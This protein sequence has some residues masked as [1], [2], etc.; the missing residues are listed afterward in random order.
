MTRT[1]VRIYAKAKVGM[2]SD[3]DFLELDPEQ[4]TLYQ[5][6]FE[7]DGVNN[8]GIT[9]WRPD[10]LA[11]MV[12]PTATGEDVRRIAQV[13][14]DHKYVM[15]D[16]DTAE[17]LVRSYIRHDDVIRQPNM[18]KPMAA[19]FNAT[20]SRVLRQM[21]A[22]ELHRLCAE[23]RGLA[24]PP[25]GLQT[26]EVI[27][28]LRKYPATVSPERLAAWAAHHP[29]RAR[30]RTPADDFEPE[31][32][33]P[34][35]TPADDFTPAD[36]GEGLG[37]RV[38]GKGSPNPSEDPLPQ[39]GEGLGGTPGERDGVTTT[40]TNYKNKRS[41]VA[42]SAQ[43]ETDPD[44]PPELGLFHA[45]PG[46]KD[47]D[48]DEATADA[49][50]TSADRDPVAAEYEQV[51]KPWAGMNP[52]DRS[53]G[54][55]PKGLT[56]YRAWRKKFPD[57]P[58]AKLVDGIVPVWNSATSDQYV[59]HIDRFIREQLW[60]PPFGAAVRDR[61]RD[62]NLTDEQRR[63]KHDLAGAHRG[64]APFENP[65]DPAAY[66]G[67]LGG[68]RRREAEERRREQQAGESPTDPAM[69]QFA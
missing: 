29:G 45:L 50:A 27:G 61:R 21:M 40:S 53:R 36:R 54:V 32:V 6:L 22:N 2:W 49:D 47:T 26:A 9:P 57:V 41:F 31:Y 48:T 25:A 10:E 51:W 19:A 17:I 58:V 63:A 28:I 46:G 69:A 55:K 66:T 33:V 68:R 37:G 42:P 1:S 3:P 4:K 5:L 39:V 15:V 64:P 14:Q 12:S 65:T 59:P 52:G 62:G 35:W 56:A 8:A 7:H 60:R 38:G 34:A 24:K 43:R 23:S 18:C 11:P 30:V 13:L 16:E 44:K 20:K 67:Q